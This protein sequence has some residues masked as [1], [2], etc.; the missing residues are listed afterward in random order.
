M[1][2]SS[3]SNGWLKRSFHDIMS[4]TIVKI[5]DCKVTDFFKTPK[6]KRIFFKFFFEV[7]VFLRN[8]KKDILKIAL[9][10]CA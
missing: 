1:F 3:L 7:L 9:D 2:V 4:L 8:T 5:W 6:G 10:I